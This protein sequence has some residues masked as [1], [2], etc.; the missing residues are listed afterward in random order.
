M[1]ARKYPDGPCR[2]CG[3]VK[4]IPARGMCRQCYNREWNA[5]EA[6]KAAKKRYWATLP[7]ERRYDYELRNKYGITLV[8]Y[9]EM[10]KAQKFR[11]LGCGK[12]SLKL[13]VDHCHVSGVV[14]GLLCH[15]CNRALGAVKDNPKTLRQ[16]AAYLEAQQ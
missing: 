14:R 4:P 16:L 11:C 5:S 2:K 6:G 13:V 1:P 7:R 12:R 9:K 10:R 8:V 3:L 15:S